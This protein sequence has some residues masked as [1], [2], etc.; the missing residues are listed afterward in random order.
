MSMTDN[1][2]PIRPVAPQ[3]ITFLNSGG[4]LR[5]VN[6]VPFV[7]QAEADKLTAESNDAIALIYLEPELLIHYETRR[8]DGLNWVTV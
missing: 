2:V 4:D 1:V 6:Q 3:Y 5:R 7:T 8:F